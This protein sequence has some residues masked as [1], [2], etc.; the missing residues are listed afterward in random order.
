[1]LA[2]ITECFDK[3]DALKGTTLRVYI[4]GSLCTG[5]S[6]NN[7]SDID[8]EM[9]LIGRNQEIPYAYVLKKLK[10]L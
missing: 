7:D 1:M 8:V 9:K 5:T 10:N 6:L 3:D 4:Y 2:R